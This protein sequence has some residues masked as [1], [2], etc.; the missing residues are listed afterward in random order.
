MLV[1]YLLNNYNKYIYIFELNF[2]IIFMILKIKK[3]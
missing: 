3:L 1:Q 2:T